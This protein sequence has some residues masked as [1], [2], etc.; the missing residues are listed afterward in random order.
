[1]IT[2]AFDQSHQRTGVA[3]AE[4]GK[5]KCCESYDI[6]FPNKR[7][8][9]M[10]ISELVKVYQS[11]YKPN[12]IT[13]ERVRTFSGGNTEN[14]FRKKG[15][16]MSTKTI[17]SLGCLVS[18][19]ADAANVQVYSIDTRSWKSKVLGSSK[20]DKD[21]AVRFIKKHGFEVDHDAADAG[22]M[23]LYPFKKGISLKEE[24]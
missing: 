5:L 6:N 20:C 2:L 10:F 3:V 23:A 4:D 7:L 8:K 19:I 18:V 24:S 16:F 9:R 11:I 22:C 15:F 21:D 17:I 1:M 12:M 13:V 14:K